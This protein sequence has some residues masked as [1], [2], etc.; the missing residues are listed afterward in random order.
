MTTTSEIMKTSPVVGMPGVVAGRGPD[1][2]EGA[3]VVRPPAYVQGTV[4]LS[5]G[6]GGGQRRATGGD[7]NQESY[8]RSGRQR[9]GSQGECFSGALY[10]IHTRHC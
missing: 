2:E 1:P 4:S 10:S 6:D 5:E 7:Y 3:A 8:D 9:T